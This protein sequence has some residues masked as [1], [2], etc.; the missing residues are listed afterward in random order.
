M[1]GTRQQLQ[2]NSLCSLHRTV[3]SEENVSEEEDF[4]RIGFVTVLNLTPEHTYSIERC[5]FH[6]QYGWRDYL[7]NRCES[8]VGGWTAV[9]HVPTLPL[10][11]ESVIV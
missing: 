11:N 1:N 5:E 2:N 6:F 3:V 4:N 9:S 7:P 8:R 10:F